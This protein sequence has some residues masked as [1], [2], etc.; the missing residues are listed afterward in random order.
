MDQPEETPDRALAEALDRLPRHAAPWGLQR[1]LAAQWS[2]GPV[3]P[4]TRRVPAWVLA[5]VPALGIAVALVLLFAFVRERDRLDGVRAG[6]IAEAVNDHLRLAARSHL[7]VEA[8]SLHTVRPW[9]IGRLDFAPVVPFGGDADLTLRGGA[10]ERFLDQTAAAFV[11]RRRLHTVTLL[12]LLADGPAWPT[13]EPAVATLRGFS[14]VVW[15]TG[16]LG[17]ALVSDVSP[18]ELRTL[19]DRFRTRPGGAS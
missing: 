16:E 11:Y 19:A 5:V 2:G 7:D 10:V 14:V 15:R 3:A 18:S 12:V 6:L 1:R 13:R 17:Y 8:S 9:F 4:R